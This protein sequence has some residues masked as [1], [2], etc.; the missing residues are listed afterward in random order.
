ML[1][2]YGNDL[3]YR[4]VETGKTS[5]TLGFQLTDQE[6]FE[7]LRQERIERKEKERRNVYSFCC[8]LFITFMSGVIW[9]SAV[10]FWFGL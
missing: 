4:H 1:N 6:K 10:A 7:E 5:T 8:L 9:T 2:D 3:Y